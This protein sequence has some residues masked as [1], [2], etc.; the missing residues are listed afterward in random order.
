L[1][2]SATLALVGGVWDSNPD[3]DPGAVIELAAGSDWYSVVLID[4][5]LQSHD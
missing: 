3:R 5:M 1:R 4:I 2:E